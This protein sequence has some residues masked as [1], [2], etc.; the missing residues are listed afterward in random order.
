MCQLYDD[1]NAKAIEEVQRMYS[2]RLLL[3]GV[4]DHQFP[5]LE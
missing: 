4:C 5:T 3:E 2:G 1:W